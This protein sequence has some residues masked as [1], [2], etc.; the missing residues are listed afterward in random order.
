MKVSKEVLVHFQCSECKGWW[1]IGDAPER[2]HWFCPW[3]GK[4]QKNENYAL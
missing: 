1:T 4:A 3:C 2:D